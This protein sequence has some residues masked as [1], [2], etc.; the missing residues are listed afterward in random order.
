MRKTKDAGLLG[1]T[2]PKSCGDGAPVAATSFTPGPWT[3]DRRGTHGV[4][5]YT[6]IGTPINWHSEI[7]RVYHGDR[8]LNGEANVRAITL[9][10]E[11]VEALRPF[12]L[13]AEKWEANPVG[14]ADEFYAIHGG[15][16][17][18]SLRLSDCRRAKELLAKIDGDAQ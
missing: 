14:T 15:A 12:A 2:G 4:A 11:L 16:D 8:F 1:N 10:P 9:V 17:G 3:S 5:N 18:A 7:A 6:I 13:F